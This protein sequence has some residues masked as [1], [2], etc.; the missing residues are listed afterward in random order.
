MNITR[1]FILCFFFFLPLIPVFSLFFFFFLFVCFFLFQSKAAYV[2]FYER[3]EM[4]DEESME[5]KQTEN[6]P[7]QDIDM[8][9]DGV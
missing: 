7:D 9:H 8:V 1:L 4:G 3:Q 6:S 5:E 2:L